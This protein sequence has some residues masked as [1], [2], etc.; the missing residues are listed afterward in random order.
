MPNTRQPGVPVISAKNYPLDAKT[1]E[2]VQTFLAQT[3]VKSR[4]SSVVVV[5]PDQFESVRKAVGTSGPTRTAFTVGNRI[6]LNGAT[7]F[8][9]SDTAS[10]AKDLGVGN[11]DHL[12]EYALSHEL[13]HMNDSRPRAWQEQHDQI[14]NQQGHKIYSDW[15]RL[16]ESQKVAPKPY[17]P[18]TTSNDP[19]ERLSMAGLRTLNDAQTIE[20]THS[21]VGTQ[22]VPPQSSAAPSS[23]PAPMSAPSSQ[24]KGLLSLARIGAHIPSAALG[25]LGAASRKDNL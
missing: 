8:P 18:P 24:P 16:S 6:Y 1:I 22:L 7:L 20:P 9:S 15:L 5:S 21:P 17:A 2:R 23:T 10:I 12:A 13:A 3:D 19:A 4:P 25:A 14:F 11:Y